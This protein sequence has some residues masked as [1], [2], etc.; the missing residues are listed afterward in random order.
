[1]TTKTTTNTHR[2]EDLN[3]RIVCYRHLG[4]SGQGCV[5]SNPKA[6]K[7]DTGLTTWKRMTPKQVAEFAQFIAQYGKGNEICE[8]CR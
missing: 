8:D 3:G 1:M 4:A 7:F 5:D 2:Y 6:T